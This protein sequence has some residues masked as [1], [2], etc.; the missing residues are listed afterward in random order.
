VVE[1]TKEF[2]MYRKLEV[3]LFRYYKIAEFLEYSLR[4][5]IKTKDP[6]F[7][8]LD[9]KGYD[10]SSKNDNGN[11]NIPFNPFYS[12]KE[13]LKVFLKMFPDKFWEWKTESQA[14]RRLILE[15]IW[16]RFHEIKFWLGVSEHTQFCGIRK[17]SRLI[18]ALEKFAATGIKEFRYDFEHSIFRNVSK[19]EINKF[20]LIVKN[21]K[22]KAGIMW[23][24]K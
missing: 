12:N 19:E 1:L 5:N 7:L 13:E 24:L 15:E 17:D 9:P 10:N 16:R 3:V 11:V 6:Y 4:F 20:V 18:T 14:D 8:I 21:R 23:L 2:E 22:R